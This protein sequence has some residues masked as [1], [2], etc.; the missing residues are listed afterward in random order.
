MQVIF[1]CCYGGLSF[2]QIAID[3]FNR[4]NIELHP[5]VVKI[6]NINPDEN[7]DDDEEY[8]VKDFRENPILIDI[9]KEFG[10]NENG[11]YPNGANGYHADLQLFTIP[12]K[13]KNFYKIEETDGFETVIIEYEKYTLHEIYSVSK[14]VSIGDNEKISKINQIFAIHNETQKYTFDY[15][16]EYI[17]YNKVSNLS[18]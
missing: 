6:I 13:Y 3:E 7:G 16:T 8:H 4:R 14:N 10:K 17:N 5:D 11:C 12:K 18:F 9:I 1:N 15:K 2:S